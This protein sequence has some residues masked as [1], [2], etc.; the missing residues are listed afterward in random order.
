MVSHACWPGEEERGG[1]VVVD[2]E[3]VARGHNVT[4]PPHRESET[5]S[6]EQPFELS[7]SP[8]LLRMYAP[9]IK[10]Q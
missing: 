2:G 9:S 10:E 5:F 1:M 8:G 6:Y 4:Y 3:L 7:V